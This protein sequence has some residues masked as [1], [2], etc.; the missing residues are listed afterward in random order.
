MPSFIEIYDRVISKEDCFQIRQ[1]FDDYPD[2]I[3]GGLYDDNE[4]VIVNV[5]EK[6]DIEVP[7]CKLSDESLPSS[8]LVPALQ[9]ALSRYH[10]KYAKS[11]ESITSWE[12]EDDY[13]LQRY[14]TTSDGFK[15]WH[16]EAGSNAT[17][18]RILAW[19]VYLNNAK[20]G[21]QFTHFKTIK[22][23]EG[24]VV[25]WPSSWTHVHRSEPNKGLK[26]IATGWV[27]FPRCH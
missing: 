3:P 20:S 11:L 13:N 5:E 6:S 17:C 1:W 8:I 27:S 14:L 18:H 4:C 12:L 26:Y 23:R 15:R 2:K 22:P 19:M 10:F 24:R 7:D 21:T 25:I 9:F 16:C